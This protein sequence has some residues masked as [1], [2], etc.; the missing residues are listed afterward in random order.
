M[1]IGIIYK[2]MYIVCVMTGP[3]ARKCTGLSSFLGLENKFG[4]VFKTILKHCTAN[5]AAQAAWNDNY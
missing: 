1:P 5:R 4:H 3:S 2:I